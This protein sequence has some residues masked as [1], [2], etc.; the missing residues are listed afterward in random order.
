MQ[1]SSRG[2]Q[3]S[4]SDITISRSAISGLSRT[5]AAFLRS[6][7][8]MQRRTRASALAF[9]LRLRLDGYSSGARQCLAG[10][11]QDESHHRD[12]I[13]FPLPLPVAVILRGR[14]N[15][16]RTYRGHAALDGGP[17]GRCTAAVR[18]AGIRCMDG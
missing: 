6:L 9:D 4:A 14:S 18:D 3:V 10:I 12:Q 15:G 8:S 13:S 1:N 17:A 7:S 5:N 2:G 11:I 16:G